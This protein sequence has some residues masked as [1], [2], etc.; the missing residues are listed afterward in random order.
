MAA[1]ANQHDRAVHAGDLLHLPDEMRVDVP[2]RAVVPRDV[3]RADRMADEEILHLAA[4][5]D[6]DRLRIGME[7]VEG[8]LGLHALHGEKRSTG[9]RRMLFRGGRGL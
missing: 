2:V 6:E 3:L 5:V 4:A 9:S 7:E 1:P 8:F